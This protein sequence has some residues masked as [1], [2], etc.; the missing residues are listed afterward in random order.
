MAFRRPPKIDENKLLELTFEGATDDSSDQSSEG[1]SIRPVRPFHPPKASLMFGYPSASTAPLHPLLTDFGPYSLQQYLR[2]EIEKTRR[3]GRPEHNEKPVTRTKNSQKEPP[4]QCRGSKRAIRDANTIPRTP[5]KPRNPK[6]LVDSSCESQHTKS[7]PASPMRSLRKVSQLR[8]DTVSADEDLAST[9]SRNYPIRDMDPSSPKKRLAREGHAL[10]PTRSSNSYGSSRRRPHNSSQ[11]VSVTDT[12]TIDLALAPPIAGSPSPGLRHHKNSKPGKGMA[13]GEFE[14]TKQLTCTDVPL[15]SPSS[16]AKSSQPQTRDNSAKNNNAELAYDRVEAAENVPLLARRYVIDCGTSNDRGHLLDEET[17]P[18]E[19]SLATGSSQRPSRSTGS[20]TNAVQP[21]PQRHR[22]PGNQGLS[23]RLSSILVPI[24]DSQS[25][26]GIV[27]VER[28]CDP[29]DR[30]LLQTQIFPIHN[31]QAPAEFLTMPSRTSTGSSRIT[32]APSSGP[33]IGSCRRREPLSLTCLP[34]VLMPSTEGVFPR[35]LDDGENFEQID[36]NV[37]ESDSDSDQNLD[38]TSLKVDGDTQPSV[39][40]GSSKVPL[41]KTFLQGRPLSKFDYSR[42][43]PQGP[44][45]GSLKV[46][47]DNRIRQQYL[48]RKLTS[49]YLTPTLNAP[50]YIF[51][52][53]PAQERQ[54]KRQ[55]NPLLGQTRHQPQLKQTIS[56]PQGWKAAELPKRRNDPPCC[57]ISSDRTGWPD[58]VPSDVFILICKYLSQDDVRNLRL[59]NTAFSRIITPIIFRNVVTKFSKSWFDVTGIQWDSRTGIPPSDW[60]LRLFGKYINKFGISF[61]V[62]MDGLQNVRSKVIQNHEQSWWGDYIWP[63]SNYPR[64]PELQAIEDLVDNNRPLLK[65]AFGYLT[66][67]SE[68]A[69]SVDSGHGWLNGPDMS[70]MAV[71]DARCELGTRVFGKTFRGENSWHEHCRDELFRWAQQNTLN[72]S[73]KVMRFCESQG[74]DRSAELL[75]LDSVQ[76]RDRD[77]FQLYNSQPDQDRHIHSGGRASPNPVNLVNLPPPLVGAQFHLG[78]L[79]QPIGPTAVRQGSWSRDRPNSQKLDP[80]QMLN[81]IPQWPIIFNG[82][83]IAAEVGGHCSWIQDKLAAAGA[84]PIQPGNLTEAQVEWLMETVWAQ[85]AFLSAYTTA[86]ITNRANLSSVH[87]LHFA[88]LSSGL[89]PALAQHEFWSALPE[90]KHITILIAPDWRREHIPGDRNFGQHM[91]INPVQAS[92]KFAEFLGQYIA[93]IE[94][95][96]KLA[97][98]FIGGG[99]HAPGIFARNQNV[100]PAPITMNP[101]GWLSPSKASARDSANSENLVKFD[102]IQDLKFENCWFTP[103][104]LESFMQTS[105]DTSLRHLTLDSVSLTGVHSNK[106]DGSLSTT[107]GPWQPRYGIGAWLQERLPSSSCWA[108]VLNRITPGVTFFERKVANGHIRLDAIDQ[109]ENV[110]GFRGNIQKISLRSCG[111]VKISGIRDLHQDGHVVLDGTRMDHGVSVRKDLLEGGIVETTT[112]QRRRLRDLTHQ[113][114]T[115]FVNTGN[116]GIQGNRVVQDDEV[117]GSSSRKNIMMTKNDPA[118]GREWTGLGKLTQVVAPVEKRVLEQAWGFVFGWGD[119]LERFKAVE[120]GWLEGGTGRFTG[121]ILKDD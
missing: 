78:N 57:P 83:N 2:A 84:F 58:H 35:D 38:L 46:E 99:E 77:S 43:V 23:P 40:Q 42:I 107:D 59:V 88:K 87:S 92:A 54:G 118:T 49:P 71:F 90:L 6:F 111:Y 1:L 10:S 63:V 119:D 62:D 34:F 12:A 112:R 7:D 31:Q 27:L 82:H 93:P 14:I 94:R 28:H 48:R 50:S 67:V 55:S 3:E 72:E 18:L 109:A 103:A 13:R 100:L 17:W 102:H 65:R 113:T 22:E 116:I 101:Q 33:I 108:A 66:K 106:S 91:L 8:P 97:I 41:S 73:A 70:D 89:L 26:S 25:S 86:V 19:G 85:R 11:S 47:S 104:M 114:V 95:L 4:T 5:V 76:V 32:T 52:E 9:S 37:P 24:S 81:T 96:S 68:L 56:L 30:A 75:F 39:C 29:S 15:F 110:R 64:F 105:R 80:K 60:M 45:N 69:L 98:G 16:G 117:E 120:D 115:N 121:V 20:I 79:Q 21:S 44:P 51:S 74:E 61:E 36:D 53:Y